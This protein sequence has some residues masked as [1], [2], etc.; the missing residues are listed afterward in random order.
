MERTLAILANEREYAQEL[1]EY[2][3][4]RDEFIF[5]ALAFSD[6][7]AV[8]EYEK[9]NSLDMLLC[10][11][12]IALTGGSEYQTDNICILSEYSF[13]RE[14]SRYPG[15]FKYQSSEQI[16]SEI[17]QLYGHRIKHKAAEALQ[18]NVRQRLICVCSPVG[19]C[20][21]STYA[22][23]LAEY[24]ARRGKTLFFSFDPFFSFPGEMKCPQDKNLTDVIYYLEQSGRE[25]SLFIQK[26]IRRMGNLDYISGVSHWF[27]I[28]D[29][30]PVH[31]R[32]L[33]EAFCQNDYYENI[34][35]DLGIIGAAGMEILMACTD[36]YA[37]IGKDIRSEQKLEE[38]K[39]Q[40]SFCGQ[41]NI[42]DKI[43]R[44]SLPYDEELNSSEYDF[45]FLLKGKLGRYIEETEGSRYSKWGGAKAA[46]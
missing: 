5:R 39:K 42:L 2:L 35:I 8:K 24:Y 41:G 23:A 4:S 43:T 11:E 10:D 1:A 9:S 20:Y 29:M 18:D 33:I 3:N 28:C 36:I 6:C 44:I 38:W 31:M 22:L 15:I 25:I 14:D 13:V 40:L 34:V 17:I 16:M 26:V 46:V 45:D 7:E 12:E 37:P 19:G 27:D 21:K 32:R 30:K